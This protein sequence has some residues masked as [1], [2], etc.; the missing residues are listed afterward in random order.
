MQTHFMAMEEHIPNKDDTTPLRGRTQNICF[1][2]YY[3]AND[4][5]HIHY[6]TVKGTSTFEISS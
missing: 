6:F 1:R 4:P 3:E 2:C 5:Y